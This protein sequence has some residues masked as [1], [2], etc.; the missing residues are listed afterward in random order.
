M[1]ERHVKPQPFRHRRYPPAHL[2]IG[3]WGISRIIFAECIP[4]DKSVNRG[5]RMPAPGAWLRNLSKFLKNHRH[6]GM[7]Q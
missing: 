3:Y 2:F 6:C 4:C 5:C 1:T 7:L